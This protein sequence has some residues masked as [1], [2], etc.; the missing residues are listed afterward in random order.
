M[1]TPRT[2]G[3][4]PG[5]PGSVNSRRLAGDQLNRVRVK[6][7]AKIFVMAM[8]IVTVAQASRSYI[9]RMLRDG[10]SM[11]LVGAW[12]GTVAAHAQDAT[13]SATPGSSDWNT[14]A[15]WVPATG[16]A[17]VP[18]GTATFGLST[19]TTITFSNGTSIDTL[20]FN[21]G[22]P[23]YT[24]N[25]IGNSCA[26]NGTGIVNNSS[27][28]P[29]INNSGGRLFFDTSTAGNATVTTNSGG[30]TNFSDTATAGNAT[31]ITNSGGD[32]AFN[33]ESTGGQA[34]FI[35]NAGGTVDL[36]DLVFAVG[37]TAGSIEGAGTYKLGSKALTVGGNDLSTEV[38][39]TIVDGGESGGTGGSLIKVGTGT[40]TLSGANTY[41]G[42]T[43]I[44]AGTLQLGDGGAS[45]SILGN[46]V[47]NAT[48][49]FDRSGSVTF[50]GAISGTGSLVQLGGGTLILTADNT[51]TGGTIV[52]AG[53]LQLG[54][55]TN[56]TSLAGAN[57]SN[58]FPGGAGK[59]AVT[60]NNSATFNVMTNASVSGGAGGVGVGLTHPGN[61]GEA[62]SFSAGG[63][64]TN[65]GTISGGAGGEG[66]QIAN[67]GNGGEAVSFS[68]GGSLTNSGTIS[69]G[70][71]GTAGPFGGVNGTGGFGVLFSGAAGT[72]TNQSGGIINGGVMMGNFANDVT[73][74]TG[75]I[76]NGILNLGPSI[77]ATLTLDGTGTQLYSTAV[78]GATTL[79]GALI[80]SGT[81]TW[82]LDESFTYTGGTTIN[83]GTLNVR[84]DNNLGAAS[85]G[86]TFDGGTL[87]WGAS[88][89]LSATPSRWKPAA[90]PSTPM[91]STPPSHRGS[92]AAAA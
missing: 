19:T 10:V 92:R 45:G 76:I 80:K 17:T 56:T 49:A 40:L 3:E 46:V 28:A 5:S 48:L 90:A 61:G 41:T 62:V 79:N 88:F 38:S 64:L 12:L 84:A 87:Q 20:Q 39:G 37:M 27:N 15:N 74:D 29:A 7:S 70:A 30:V 60:V 81:G 24:F 75:S 16:P 31:I 78:T 63:S 9:S 50:S 26:I 4:V 25:L 35:T 6:C 14:A 73:L 67:G 66:A 22:A 54:D 21:A 8:P 52:N 36:S 13:W 68:A 82:T 53:T 69:G 85:G 91:A 51:Y 71:A 55:G 65:S 47:N 59:D 58:G 86:L 77:A 34:R 89:N 32:T 18:T 1:D 44:S 72:L 57:G 43:T 11:L 83:A 42:G 33:E 23:A 2:I